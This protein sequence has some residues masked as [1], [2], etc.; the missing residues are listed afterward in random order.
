[1]KTCFSCA[2]YCHADHE[3]YAHEFGSM[4]ITLRPWNNCEAWASDGLGDE[5]RESLYP[6][7]NGNAAQ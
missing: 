4:K 6:H 2:W 7:D 5:E 3:C 1:M